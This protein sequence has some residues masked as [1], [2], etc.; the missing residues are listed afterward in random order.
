MINWQNSTRPS[1]LTPFNNT[2]Y[3]L[4]YIDVCCFFDRI[5]RACWE[6]N[7]F[8]TSTQNTHTTRFLDHQHSASQ[9]HTSRINLPLKS[10]SCC[11]SFFKRR[12][13]LFVN[14]KKEQDKARRP[15]TRCTIRIEAFI[16]EF[17]Y[18]LYIVRELLFIR[19]NYLKRSYIHMHHSKLLYYH[20]A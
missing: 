4:C 14:L 19:A 18:N 20:T 7:D 9:S 5:E 16:F 17:F 6:I 13:Q 2:F 8:A 3:T 10:L 1:H 12:S 11:V 15:L